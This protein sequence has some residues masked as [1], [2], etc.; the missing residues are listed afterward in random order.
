MLFQLWSFYIKLGMGIMI[1]WPLRILSIVNHRLQAVEENGEHRQTCCWFTRL[2][3]PFQ[4][5]ETG[6]EPSWTTFS[7]LLAIDDQSKMYFDQYWRGNM[8]A[9]HSERNSHMPMKKKQETV[10]QFY[11]YADAWNGGILIIFVFLLKK[12]WITFPQ[13]LGLCVWQKRIFNGTLSRAF[14][15]LDKSRHSADA[16]SLH[17]S[18]STTWQTLFHPVRD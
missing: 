12:H 9:E 18:L 2:H 16:D 5:A 11:P 10:F 7:Q 1:K 6:C 3:S 13:Q 14:V 8:H 4:S 17:I 15:E